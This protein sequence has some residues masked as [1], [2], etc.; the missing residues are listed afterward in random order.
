MQNLLVYLQNLQEYEKFSKNIQFAGFSCT[1]KSQFSPN[2]Y[3]VC[4]Q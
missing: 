1:A 4:E 2:P 3:I